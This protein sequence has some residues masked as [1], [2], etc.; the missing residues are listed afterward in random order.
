MAGSI[1]APVTKE[2]VVKKALGLAG[3]TVAASVPPG[4]KSIYE[5]V[6]GDSSLTF[7]AAALQATGLDSVLSDPALVATVFAPTDAAFTALLTAL[8][9][10]PQAVSAAVFLIFCSWFC[11]TSSS[12]LY[13]ATPLA[14]NKS[15]TYILLF[16]FNLTAVVQ[17]RDYLDRAAQVPRNPWPD[18]HQG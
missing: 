18:P 11:L 2:Y 9:L 15:L 5:V 16:V 7:L 14:Y 1:Q 6:K 12:V 13:N 17:R 8:N 3:S 4:C 10:T